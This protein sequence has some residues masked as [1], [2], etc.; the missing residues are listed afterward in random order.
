[1]IAER[2][3]SELKKEIFP[4][5]PD[6]EFQ[7]TVS[8]GLAEYKPQE[9]LKAFVQRVDQLMYQAKK[10]GENCICADIEISELPLN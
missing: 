10:N 1:V 3:R 4:P 5:T 7:M 8:I 6:K 2:I 9:G